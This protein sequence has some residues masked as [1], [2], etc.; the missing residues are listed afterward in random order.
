MY[1]N[2][3][4]KF[5]SHIWDFNAGPFWQ[6]HAQSP[7]WAL[8]PRSQGRPCLRDDLLCVEWNAKPYALSHLRLVV[9][10][11][12]PVCQSRVFL[13]CFTVRSCVAACCLEVKRLKVK[14][15]NI[16]YSTAYMSQTQEQQR[17]ALSKVAADC[18]ELMIPQ[19][20][21]RPSDWTAVQ[22]ADIP[23]P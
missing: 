23:L 2:S 8:L 12:T 17:F 10:Y 22:L 5:S 4:D 1:T 3:T 9:L 7:L 14:C 6:P 18:H 11:L 21:M 15:Q 13:F 19:H 16:C 20:I